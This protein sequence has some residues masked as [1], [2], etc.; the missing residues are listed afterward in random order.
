MHKE[1]TSPK[2]VILQ[3]TIDSQDPSNRYSN[4]NIQEPETTYLKHIAAFIK[5]DI[6]HFSCDLKFVISK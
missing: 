2:Q 1:T 3:E 4:L 5:E 6:C